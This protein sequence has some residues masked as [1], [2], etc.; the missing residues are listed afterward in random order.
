MTGIDGQLFLLDIM[1]AGDRR[2]WRATL[3][4]HCDVIRLC[5]AGEMRLE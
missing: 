4:A 3:V 2:C 5:Q 1:D